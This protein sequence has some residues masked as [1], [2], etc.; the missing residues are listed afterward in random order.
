MKEIV[1]ETV[2][3]D[4]DREHLSLWVVGSFGQNLL[5]I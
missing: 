3:D 5:D 2:D 4:H 1:P